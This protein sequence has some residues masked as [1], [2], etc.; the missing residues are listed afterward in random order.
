MTATLPFVATVSLLVLV[1]SADAVPPNTEIV[2]G[3][4]V[5]AITLGEP[6]SRVERHLGESELGDTAMGRFWEVWPID[7][8]GGTIGVFCRRPDQH[9]F[10]V[11]RI[12]STSTRYSLAN[13]IGIGSKFMDIQQ[14]FPD[15][16]RIATY[17]SD[18]RQQQIEVYD[19]ANRGIAFEI[20]LAH[21]HP[22]ARC[23]AFIIHVPKSTIHVRGDQL[24][25]W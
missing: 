23:T 21:A 14:R 18:Q 25:Q 20:A 19:S 4:S 1:S 7:K 15:L 3:K 2:P 12:R 6:L 5:G 16:V 13:S 10:V 9:T 8:H 11:E 17:Y 24:D 22:S